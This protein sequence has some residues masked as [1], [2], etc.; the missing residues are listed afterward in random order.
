VGLLSSLVGAVEVPGGTTGW[1][2]RTL[3]YPG[4][5]DID[6]GALNWSVYKGVDGFLQTMRFGGLSG[7]WSKNI[8]YSSEWP[9]PLP[10]VRHEATLRDINPIGGSSYITG[11]S[12]RDEVW[13]KVGAT[14][15]PEMMFSSSNPVLS[16]GNRDSVAQALKEIPFYVAYELFNSETTEGFADIVLPATC[17]LEEDIWGWGLE[18]NFNHAFGMADWCV[19]IAQRVVAP[20]GERK[21][22]YEV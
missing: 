21:S 11:G 1:P 3:G 9:V 18:Q 20:I 16:V 4:R 15:K 17:S 7:S 2:A 10:E 6:P 12:D 8:P 13:K 5:E 19:H 14:Y 22:F